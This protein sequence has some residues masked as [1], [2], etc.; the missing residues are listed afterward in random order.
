MHSVV[1]KKIA[2][3]LAIAR[4]VTEE[5]VPMRIMKID[6]VEKDANQSGTCKTIRFKNAEDEDLR[7][8]NLE[9]YDEEMM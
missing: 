2:N 5:K 3:K 7:G 8:S 4:I 1:A 6:C 9:K